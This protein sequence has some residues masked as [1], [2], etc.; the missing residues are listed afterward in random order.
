MVPAG[1]HE[2]SYP[3]LPLQCPWWRLAPR[4]DSSSLGTRLVAAWV[5]FIFTSSL[6]TPGLNTWERSA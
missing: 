2:P 6:Q 4:G 5:V 1:W 3:N